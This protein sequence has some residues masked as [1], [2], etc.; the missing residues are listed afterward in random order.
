MKRL[1]SKRGR[2]EGIPRVCLQMY[3]FVPGLGT[4]VGVISAKVPSNWYF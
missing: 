1:S 3:A 2:Y 4:I